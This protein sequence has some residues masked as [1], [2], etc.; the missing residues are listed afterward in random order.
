MI[1]LSAEPEG[2]QFMEWL[3]F[4][5]S[6]VGW[7]LSV[8]AAAVIALFLQRWFGIRFQQWTVRV[9]ALVVPAE[10]AQGPH[11][12]ARQTIPGLVLSLRLVNPSMKDL[13]LKIPVVSGRQD[14]RLQRLRHKLLPND[15]GYVALA[16]GVASSTHFIL[17]DTTPMTFK[18]IL[19][20]PIGIGDQFEYRAEFRTRASLE[21]F[22]ED[23][24]T[25]IGFVDRFY[26]F[27]GMSRPA[28]E[29]KLN[30]VTGTIHWADL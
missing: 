4:L 30:E 25:D 19:N 12:R 8:A 16:T 11:Q 20:N 27:Y 17:N 21:Q 24:W 13:R 6:F 14:T 15:K 22:L 9:E 5:G 10:L 2:S 26:V 1:V 23:P 28:L 18:E 7:L 29:A 3:T